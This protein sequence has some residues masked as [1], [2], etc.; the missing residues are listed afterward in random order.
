MVKFI[1]KTLCIFIYDSK[2]INENYIIWV[3]VL[4]IYINFDFVDLYIQAIHIK[5]NKIKS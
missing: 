3:V 2:N 1:L 4:Y 5:R